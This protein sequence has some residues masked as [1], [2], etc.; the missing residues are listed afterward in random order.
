MYSMLRFNKIS[1][2]YWFIKDHQ[3]WNW[4]FLPPNLPVHFDTILLICVKA[5]QFAYTVTFALSVDMPR[6]W[7]RGK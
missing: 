6:Q 5:V 7:E 1:N 4:L 2:F 3:K